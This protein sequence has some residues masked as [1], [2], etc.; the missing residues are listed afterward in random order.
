MLETIK[1]ANPLEIQQLLLEIM[2]LLARSFILDDELYADKND[3]FRQDFA[4]NPDDVLMHESDWHQWGIITHTRQMDTARLAAVDLLGE[5]FQ[6]A[7]D[8]LSKAMVG[9]FNKW[10]LSLVLAP[11]VHDWGKFIRREYL[12]F[13]PDGRPN[14]N[15]DGHEFGSGLLVRRFKH[16]LTGF[17]LTYDQV[18]YLARCAELH[19]ELGKV[20]KEA[21]RTEGGYTFAFVNGPRC[22]EACEAIIKSNSDLAEEIG[23]LFAVDSLAKVGVISAVEASSDVDL[24]RFKTRVVAEVKK[25]GLPE[26]YVQAGLKLGLDLALARRY[27]SI[28]NK[29]TRPLYASNSIALTLCGAF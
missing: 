19:F 21:K 29:M 12:G 22:A 13:K 7:G 16:F 17:N 15:F 6:P 24:T 2:P 3:P 20:R 26:R 14:F 11:V 9:H 27:F 8:R 4:N 5:S 10:Q 25:D 18:E 23:A 1:K 28:L